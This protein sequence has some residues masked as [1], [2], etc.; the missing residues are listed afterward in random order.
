MKLE[1][2]EGFQGKSKFARN[3]PL[4]T[5]KMSS[6]GYSTVMHGKPAE[7][8]P[9]FFMTAKRKSCK[10]ISVWPPDDFACLD[11]DQKT[12]VIL[13]LACK[14]PS[15]VYEGNAFGQTDFVFSS[16]IGLLFVLVSCALDI[17]INMHSI[18]YETI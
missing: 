6:T 11:D 14:I 5:L 8:G 9:G 13:D 7:A 15:I 17:L 16:A 4:V 12:A 10:L 1:D 18:T 3:V 2:G